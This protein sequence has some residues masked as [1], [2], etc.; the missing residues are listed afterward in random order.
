MNFN[1]TNVESENKGWKPLKAGI[2]IPAILE[3]VEFAKDQNGTVIDDL[4]FNFKGTGK[5]NTGSMA[6]RIWASTFDSNNQYYDNTGVKQERTFAQI[7]HI[8]AAYLP[9]EAV[10]KVTGSDWKS[11]AKSIISAL[12][13]NVSKRGCF[14]KVILDG[15]DKATFPLFPDFI[16]TDLTPDRTLTLNT[17]INPKTNLP[18]E[19]ITPS[20]APVSNGSSTSAFGGTTSAPAPSF[21]SPAFGQ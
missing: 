18:F 6:F 16:V 13:G 8:L 12:S 11:F 4:L 2:D 9:Q 1:L 10:E 5:N 17:K 15:K 21:G 19:R 3:S 20:E 7:K 14:L